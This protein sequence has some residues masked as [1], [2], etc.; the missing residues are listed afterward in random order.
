MTKIKELLNFLEEV[1]PLQ[2]QESYD[3]SGLIYGNKNEKIQGVLI[4]L[5]LTEAVIDEAIA[6]GCNL[7]ISHHPIIFRG[8][9]KFEGHY[10]DRIIVKAIKADIAIYAIHTNLDNVLENGVNGK[11]AEMLMLEEPMVLKPLDEKDLSGN[12]GA[13][14]IGYVKSPMMPMD[15]LDFLKIQMDLK[16]IKHTKLPNHQ[17]DKIAVCG[18]SGSFLLEAA[19]GENAHVFITS[20]FK[21]H[22][23]FEADNEIVIIDI[24]HYESERFTIN[25]LYEIIIKNFSNFAAHCTKINTN[26]IKYY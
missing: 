22:E 25:L 10:V 15:F 26:P 9:K 24:G 7:I 21:Y 16:V 1:A 6:L 5:D 20:D 14:V 2:L 19:K 13:G 18:G 23:F 12:I 3:N 11:I 17:V 4:S 8:I